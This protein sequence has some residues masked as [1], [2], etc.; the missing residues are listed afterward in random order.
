MTQT[1]PRS[2]SSRQ[3]AQTRQRRRAAVREMLYVLALL[4]IAGAA[5]YGFALFPSKLRTQE[6]QAEHDALAKDVDAL[7]DSIATLRRDTRAMS[8]DPWVVEHALRGRLGYLRAG[9]RVF[10]PG[11]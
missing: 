10:R 1:T 11:S 9:E 4:S 8:D 2:G 7:Q 6:L 5:Y 3:Q